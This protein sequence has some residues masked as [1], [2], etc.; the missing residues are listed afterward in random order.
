MNQPILTPTYLEEYFSTLS[1][2]IQAKKREIVDVLLKSSAQTEVTEAYNKL[3]FKE[4]IEFQC[5]AFIRWLNFI[6]NT[7]Y[8]SIFE[9]TVHRLTT[10]FM[11]IETKLKAPEEQKDKW[12]YYG[13]VTQRVQKALTEFQPHVEIKQGGSQDLPQESY[14]DIKIT[15]QWAIGKL[16]EALDIWNKQDGGENTLQLMSNIYVECREILMMLKTR[17]GPSKYDK[18]DPQT[19]ILAS[20]N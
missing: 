18:E 14:N 17:F 5:D 20:K 16:L 3:D 12:L 13:L 8:V 15:Y 4:K 10:M 2:E 6:S 19:S 1:N 9:Y 7:D 11:T